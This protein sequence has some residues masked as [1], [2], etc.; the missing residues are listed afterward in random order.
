MENIRPICINC[1]STMG[2]KHMSVFMFENKYKMNDL[3]LY[4]L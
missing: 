3:F 1:N 2:A 4:G